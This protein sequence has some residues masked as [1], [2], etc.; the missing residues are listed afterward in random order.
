MGK[1]CV[2]QSLQFAY[3]LSLTWFGPGYSLIKKQKEIIFR[4]SEKVVIEKHDLHST[5]PVYQQPETHSTIQ[6][7]I[8]LT[9]T[10]GQTCYGPG[11]RLPVTA[12]IQS[13]RFNPF[14]LRS[15]QIVLKERISFKG[16]PSIKARLPVTK[17]KIICESVVQMGV[18]LNHDSQVVHDLLC[19][20]PTSHQAAT[21]MAA[22]HIDIKYTIVVNALIHDGPPV[23]I[24]IPVIISNWKRCDRFFS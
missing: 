19:M 1:R 17:T 10:R 9:V 18:A 8:K 7:G 5:W 23:D 24:E 22:R 3:S 13:L 11:D 4:T 14:V 15:F 16:R 2:G 12:A 21:L 6:N 20:L